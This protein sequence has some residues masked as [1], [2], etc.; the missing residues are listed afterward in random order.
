MLAD[1]AVV[2]DDSLFRCY[3]PATMSHLDRFKN[4]VRGL[5]REV[6][7]EKKLARQREAEARVVERQAEAERKQRA[8]RLFRELSEA[9]NAEHILRR[10]KSEYLRGSGSLSIERPIYQPFHVYSVTYGRDT[11]GDRTDYIRVE[12]NFRQTMVLDASRGAN[13]VQ[14]FK[15]VV[16]A[17]D[18]PKYGADKATFDLMTTPYRG[19]KDERWIERLLGHGSGDT[20][21][22][23]MVHH[24]L[25]VSDTE[26]TSI[27]NRGYPPGY[28]GVVAVGDLPDFVEKNLCEAAYESI[29]RYKRYGRN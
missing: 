8:E 14:I 21:Y 13:F 16:E 26:G 17:V 7:E 24:T 22:A 1:D 10:I 15:M 29:A 25:T 19:A 28:V 20:N 5:D 9:A 27:E 4:L 3:I 11:G 6:A 18:E 12:T 23:L 2:L